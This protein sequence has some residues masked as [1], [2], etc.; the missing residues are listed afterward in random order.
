MRKLVQQSARL[1]MLDLDYNISIASA[2]CRRNNV[3]IE[4]KGDEEYEA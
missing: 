3:F 1:D 4:W 2:R